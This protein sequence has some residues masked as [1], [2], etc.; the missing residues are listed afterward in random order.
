[1]NTNDKFETWG[2][3]E[4]F[5]HQKMAGLISEQ[6]LGGASMIRIDVPETENQPSFSRLLNVSAIYAINPTD[7]ATAKA[8]AGRFDKK[9][10]ETWD[11]K[12]VIAKQ[13]LA[14]TSSNDPDWIQQ[15]DD[16]DDDDSPF[17]L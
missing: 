9:P 6:V 7:E 1:M 14:L 5:G 13:K 4:L 16:E 3:I 17:G 15:E 8:M 12:N 10:I 11:I 2:I